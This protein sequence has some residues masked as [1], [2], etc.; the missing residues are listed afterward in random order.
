MFWVF[1]S[2]NVISAG[3]GCLTNYLYFGQNSSHIED[4]KG[5]QLSGLDVL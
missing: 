5:Y 1:L 3:V 2:F 4:E